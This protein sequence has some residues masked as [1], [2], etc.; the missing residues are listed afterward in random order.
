MTNTDLAKIVQD[1]AE[2]KG[3]L[4]VM[5]LAEAV[6]DKT[7]LSKERTRKVWRGLFESKVGDYIIVMGFLEGD[8]VIPFAGKGEG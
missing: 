2:K 1:A 3:Y 6:H 7:G 8:I 5:A 4:K